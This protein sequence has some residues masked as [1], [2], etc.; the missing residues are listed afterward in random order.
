MEL[1]NKLKHVYCIVRTVYEDDELKHVD[2]V[3]KYKSA[4]Y[5]AN[6][7]IA[8]LRCNAL[9]KEHY[10]EHS[11]LPGFNRSDYYRPYQVLCFDLTLS[12]I[13]YG[14]WEVPNA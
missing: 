1:P 10:E 3:S 7:K 2:M 4:G 6:K 14:T 13:H 5:Y 8:I 11:K 12:G 9:N